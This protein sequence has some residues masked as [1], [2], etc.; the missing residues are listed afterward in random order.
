LDRVRPRELYSW[1]MP[2]R[3]LAWYKMG[4]REL[5]FFQSLRLANE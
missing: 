4:I 2:R 5:V 3:A 1:G